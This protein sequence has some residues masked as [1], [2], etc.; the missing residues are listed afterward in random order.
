MNAFSVVRKATNFI[1]SHYKYKKY[2]IHNQCVKNPCK[3]S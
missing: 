2:G 1:L 3:R